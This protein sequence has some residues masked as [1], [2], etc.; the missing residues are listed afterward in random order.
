MNGA[1]YFLICLAEECAELQRAVSKALRFGLEDRLPPHGTTNAEDLVSAYIDIKA[2]MESLTL[3]GALKIPLNNHE[4][5]ELKKGRIMTYA[6]YS[7]SK[8]ILSH[9]K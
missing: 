3:S 8:G 9:A 7:K 1:E 6:E 4:Q 5:I 2:I